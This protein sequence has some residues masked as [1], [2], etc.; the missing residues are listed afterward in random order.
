M[1]SNN[2]I[3]IHGAD[4]FNENN[5][6]MNQVDLELKKGEFAYL[7][8]KTGGGKSTFL[9]TL[10][11]EIKLQE[12][13]GEVAGFD[14]R[15]LTRRQIPKLR[16]K[17]GIVFQDFQLLTDRNVMDNLLF[18][19]QATGW[20]DSLKM[21]NRA[22]EVLDLVGLST[23]DYKMPH[24]LSGGEQQ[25]L[26]IAR[27]ILNSPEL[28]LADEPTGNLDP[29]LS[30]DI[31]KLLMDISTEENAS[32]LM[33]THDFVLL[34]KFPSKVFKINAGKIETLEDSRGARL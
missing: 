17:L 22:R 33:A 16:R 23:K 14:L 3:S 34:E 2:V 6:V 31:V 21:K 20:K 26:V 8:G 7:I 9:K 18:V 29:D 10:Y 13:S 15:K 27:A 5:L 30:E 1:E 19:L 25:R 11:G 24:Q 32:V 28:I 12:G 4:F